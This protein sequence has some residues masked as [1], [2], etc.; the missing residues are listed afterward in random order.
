MEYTIENIDGNAF[1]LMGYTVQAMKRERFP[2]DAIDSYLNAA[3]SSDYDN[4]V[5]VTLR[6]IAE[7]NDFVDFWN[8]FNAEYGYIKVSKRIAAKY[9]WYEGNYTDQ[10]RDYILANSLAEEVE[11]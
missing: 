1:S 9:F 6:Q 10:F 4:L 8:A 11:L 3:K 2:Q 7:V 5:D